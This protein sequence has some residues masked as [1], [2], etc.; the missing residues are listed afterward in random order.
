MKKVNISLIII[1]SI[2]SIIK[3]LGELDEEIVWILKDL[4]IILT[5]S[6]PYIISKVFKVNI[7]EGLSFMY[8]I[9]YGRMIKQIK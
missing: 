3:V 2:L 5:V 6:L 7:S 8:I 1:I 4:S 9:F